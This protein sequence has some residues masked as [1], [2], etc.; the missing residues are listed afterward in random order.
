MSGR[1]AGEVVVLQTRGQR[2]E[3]LL[4]LL[5]LSAQLSTLLGHINEPAQ[6]NSELTPIGEDGVGG[7]SSGGVVTNLH[8]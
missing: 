8:R 3:L 2:S 4:K 6:W 7:T 5:E 1:A